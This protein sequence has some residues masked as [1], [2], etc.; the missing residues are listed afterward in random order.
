MIALTANREQEEPWRIKRLKA[1][2][3]DCAGRVLALHDYEGTLSVNWSAPPMID[4]LVSV[5][6]AWA[7][8]GEWSINHY[9]CGVEI[10]ID[11]DAANP[12]AIAEPQ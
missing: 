2:A 10:A 9:V 6:K 8:Q 3:Q 1:V 4:D 7:L 11:C 12:F 5:T